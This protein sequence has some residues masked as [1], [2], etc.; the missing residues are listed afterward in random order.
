MTAMASKNKISGGGRG[1]IDDPQASSILP[2]VRNSRIVFGSC[3]SQYYEQ[4][5]WDV[6]IQRHPTAFVWAGDAVYADD[7]AREPWPKKDPSCSPIE[8]SDNKNKKEE[9]TTSDLISYA[10]PEYLHELFSKQ[11]EIESYKQLLEEDYGG[12]RISIFGAIDDHDYGINNGDKTFPFRKENGVEFTRFLGLTKES[13]AMARRA[14]EGL[15]VYGVQVYDFSSS[16]A[17]PRL[18]TDE[19]AGLDPDVT[20]GTDRSGASITNQLVAVFVLDIRSNK[21]PWT[22]TFPERYSIDPDGDFLGEDQWRWFEEA[23]GRSNASV[24]IVVSGIQVHAPWF[25]DSNKVENW[26]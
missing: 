13:S 14:E 16:L 11:L 7:Q 4:P 22:K 8:T 10:T 9:T 26:R 2:S 25:Y 17:N 21:T 23:I 5:F 15:G 3:N 19:E 1:N 12:G 20:P 24:N 18:L 6:I